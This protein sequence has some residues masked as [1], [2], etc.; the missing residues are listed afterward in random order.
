MTPTSANDAWRRMHASLAEA[1]GWAMQAD[2]PEAAARQALVTLRCKL[3]Y[4]F[5]LLR[6]GARRPDVPR[7]EMDDQSTVEEDV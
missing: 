5:E 1:A 7:V 2:D 4:G 3:N 6:G